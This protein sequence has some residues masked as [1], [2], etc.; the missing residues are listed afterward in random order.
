MLEEMGYAQAS[1]DPQGRKLYGLT[2]EGEKV[3]GDNKAQIDAIFARFGGSELLA[4]RGCR[5]GQA[6]HAQ[7]AFRASAAP[8]RPRRQH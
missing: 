8:A 3:L 2:S 1:Q 7:S 6:S 5:L 4:R